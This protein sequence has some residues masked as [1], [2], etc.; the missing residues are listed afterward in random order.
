[1]I[2]VLFFGVIAPVGT[3]FLFDAVLRIVAP[4]PAP[5]NRG[6]GDI[7]GISSGAVQPGLRSFHE[8]NV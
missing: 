1:M 8:A 3:A 7:A 2:A 4:S 6:A 5:V